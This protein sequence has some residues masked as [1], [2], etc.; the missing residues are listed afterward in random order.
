MTMRR[1]LVALAATLLVG[2]GAQ[3]ALSQTELEASMHYERTN[4]DGTINCKGG[5]V[6]QPLC[7]CC[8]CK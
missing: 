4:G 6:V 1:K 3:S 5:C 2:F 8:S 7:Y